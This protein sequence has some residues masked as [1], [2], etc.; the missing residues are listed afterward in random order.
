MKTQWFYI[1]FFFALACTDPSVDDFRS[2]G[3][4]SPDPVGIIEGTILYV[5]PRPPCEHGRPLG[6]VVLTL[7]DYNNPPPPSGSASSALNLLTV[8]GSEF[9]GANDC[10]PSDPSAA[11]LAETLTRS[12]AFIWPEIQ[13]GIGR[14]DAVYQVRAF[15][16]STGDF[17]PFFSVT[18]SPTQGDI[19]GGAF[20]DTFR[21]PPLFAEIRFSGR[22]IATLGEVI[23]G[24]SI[25]LG[26]PINTVP[27]VFY[28]HPET[29]PLSTEAIFPVS[30]DPAQDE[31]DLY[32]LAQMRL[33]LYERN[34]GPL[35]SALD[36]TGLSYAFE[37]EAAY[38]WYVRPD[39]DTNLDGIADLHPILGSTLGIAW[40][41]PVMYMQ[42]ARSEV[43]IA[44]RIPEVT[45]LPSPRPLHL[46][47]GKQ[48]FYPDIEMTIPPAAVVKLSS[49]SPAC[50]VPYFAPGNLA[51]I[52]E[53]RTSE[54]QELPSGIYGIS[55]LHGVAGASVE[56]PLPPLDDSI[57][58]TGMNLSGGQYSSQT[59]TIPNE[60]G[61]YLQVCPEDASGEPSLCEEVAPEQGIAGAYLV[62]DPSPNDEAIG[63]SDE[64]TGC[65]QAFDPNSNSIRAIQ[66]TDYTEF[67]EQAE[68][69]RNL[70]CS[71]V[72]HLCDVP[73]CPSTSLTLPSGE[74][75]I[76]STPTEISETGIPNCVPFHMPEFCCP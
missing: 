58:E 61:D 34:G 3:G 60:L 28:L 30:A 1:S 13:L 62:Y 43:E 21:S 53:S 29:S 35:Q 47:L 7:F 76:R 63:R 41:T 23:S 31:A 27:P 39:V 17:N 44:A 70:C 33:S 8:P 37:N 74:A 42:R 57:S 19:A 49:A 18:R 64:R 75:F 45:L 32:N 66:Y 10:L 6:R 36:E 26:A 5:G 50:Q 20:V 65:T 11:E 52:Y 22:D 72:S 12:A 9:F 59:W 16:D 46:A 25:T 67:G 73:L 2:Q 69:L 38:A 71:A 14:D 51:P 56:A 48:V 24:V 54:C 15:Y 4:A 55:V 68:A 40:H